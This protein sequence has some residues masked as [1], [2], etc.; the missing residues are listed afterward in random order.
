MISARLK[1]HSGFVLVVVVASTATALIK[2]HSVVAGGM[3]LLISLALV[4]LWRVP[5]GGRSPGIPAQ[6]RAPGEPFHWGFRVA[7]D[8]SREDV[9]HSLQDLG[10]R[11]DLEDGRNARLEGGSQLRTRTFGG[12][13]VNPS[14]LPITV[15]VRKSDEL[16]A[17]VLIEVEDRLGPIAVRDRALESRYALRAQEIKD[18]ISQA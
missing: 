6:D 9:L 11:L 1:D 12:Y 3:G 7:R 15:S 18:A 5:E 13:F 4:A 2:G 14:H 17:P 16:G 10:L 8:S